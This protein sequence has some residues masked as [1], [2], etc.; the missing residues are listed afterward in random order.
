MMRKEEGRVPT[1]AKK[2]NSLA[3]Q[4]SDP[5]VQVTIIIGNSKKKRK[6]VSSAFPF[7]SSAITKKEYE[8]RTPH[9]SFLFLFVLLPVEK[10]STEIGLC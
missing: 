6:D 10:K 2:K 7:C 5:A 4:R 9:F 1:H 3:V 8:K